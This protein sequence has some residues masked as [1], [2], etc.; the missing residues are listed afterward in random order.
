M[1]QIESNK[2]SK[3]N[4]HAYMYISFLDLRGEIFHEHLKSSCFELDD[5]SIRTAF[6]RS[7]SETF[8]LPRKE[9]EKKSVIWM[10]HQ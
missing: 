7:L 1:Q 6:A 3:S 9:K 2:S 4:F 5:T 8:L 10:W